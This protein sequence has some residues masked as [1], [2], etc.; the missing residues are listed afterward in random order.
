M[1]L[2]EKEEILLE[3]LYTRRYTYGWRVGKGNKAAAEGLVEK[4]LAEIHRYQADYHR[5]RI[6]IIDEGKAYVA[7]HYKLD[8]N[9]NFDYD[10]VTK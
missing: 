4:G 7:K 8:E 3:R 6:S 2:T 5:P 1:E 10:E 9:G